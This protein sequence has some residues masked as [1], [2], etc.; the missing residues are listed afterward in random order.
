M[1][2]LDT[3]PT[4][5]KMILDAIR[6]VQ[7]NC[8][9]TRQYVPFTIFGDNLTSISI[10]RDQSEIG[11][12]NFLCGRWGVTWKEAQKLHYLKIKSKKSARL[13]VIAILKK[14][15][16]LRWD[17][18]QFRN[19]ALHSPTGITAI[20]SHHSL[21]YKI[22]EEIRR[23]KDG[24]NRADYHL[25][26]SPHTLANLQSSTTKIK[27]LWLEE[28]RLARME[29]V[30]PD[31]D[32]TRQAIS[33]RSQIQAFLGITGP[34][35]PPPSRKRPVAVQDNRITEEAQHR[36]AVNFF[37]P[38]AAKRARVTPTVTTT[39]DTLR[40]QTLFDTR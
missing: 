15:M 12:T 22:E 5:Q 13:W 32:V 19:T 36:A 16:L 1:E 18:W 26:S 40:Q 20:I 38:N 11:W 24:I 34:F 7:K 23:G 33:Q 4:L 28:V 39:T 30:E 14:L 2:D 21:N 10:F 9:P 3:E 25:F 27:E 37:G 17:M 35:T 31:D 6:Q 29:Y 8:V